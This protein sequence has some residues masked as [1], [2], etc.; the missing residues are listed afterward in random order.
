M[1]SKFLAGGFLLLFLFALIATPAVRALSSGR[2]GYSGNPDPAHGGG[3]TCSICHNG[4]TVPEVSL[5][6]PTTVVAGHTYLYSLTIAGGQALNPDAPAPAGG[7]NVSTTSGEILSLS[8]DTYVESEEITHSQPKPADDNNEVI[9]TFG[10]TAPLTP[11][12]AILYG[13]GNSVNG[14]FTFFGDAATT[15]ALTLTV[16][17]SDSASI[18]LTTTVSV[19]ADTC[20]ATSDLIIP[21]GA[22]VYFCYTVANTGPV[23]LSLHTL[24]DSLLGLIFEDVAYDLAPGA[25]VNNLDLGLTISDLP[26]ITSTYFATW[27]AS[28]ATGASAVATAMATVEVEQPTDV[29]LSSLEGKPAGSSILAGGLGALALVG[30]VIL[31]W[32]RSLRRA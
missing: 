25:T 23:T 9:F 12:D 14:D 32:R 27:T 18:V 16:V 30:V 22:T 8:D 13:A 17:P 3:N 5:T 29:S 6:G 24:E 11:T 15:D 1:Q 28:E 4:G 26:E 10:W 2:I 19:E 20:G 21:F 7:F 31:M